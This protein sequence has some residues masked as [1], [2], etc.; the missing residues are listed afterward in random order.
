MFPEEEVPPLAQAGWEAWVLLGAAGCGWA[1]VL[2]RLVNEP[3]TLTLT[4]TL[5]MG[6]GLK[7]DLWGGRGSKTWDTSAT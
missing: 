5:L 2:S 3:V 6:P 7:Q 4:L 1:C